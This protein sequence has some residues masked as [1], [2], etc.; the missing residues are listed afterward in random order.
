[1]VLFQWMHLQRNGEWPFVWSTTWWRYQFVDQVSQ[2][3]ISRQQHRGKFS[4]STRIRTPRQDLKSARLSKKCWWTHPT[5][6]KF[7][8]L[9]GSIT[10]IRMKMWINSPPRF[11]AQSL[12]AAT[13]FSWW[14]SSMM[15]K[16]N[17]KGARTWANLWVR[18]SP[19]FSKAINLI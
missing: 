2:P 7:G 3:K 12:L 5:M 10:E 4:S 9:S 13:S 6:K 1:M 16:L 19:K 18:S 8:K 11:Y 17:L 15:R 14:T